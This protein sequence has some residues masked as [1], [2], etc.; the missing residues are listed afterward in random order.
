MK[1][2]IATADF[3]EI[4]NHKT[5]FIICLGL[6]NQTFFK[7]KSN[8]SRSRHTVLLRSGLCGLASQALPSVSL[9]YRDYV[10]HS[11]IVTCPYR[12][13]SRSIHPDASISLPMPYALYVSL[14]SCNVVTSYRFLQ[15]R[16]HSLHK[17]NLR[18]TVSHFFQSYN[19]FA[20]TLPR[21]YEAV[22]RHVLGKEPRP[23]FQILCSL[24][25]P[26]PAAQL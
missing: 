7:H 10:R 25:N 13:G 16:S 19:P 26:R 14:S 20:C 21:L 6:T 8:A 12:V 22:S 2:E 24:Y 17:P 18:T 4:W 15:S 11:S 3:G 9:S 1:H 5:T 23:E